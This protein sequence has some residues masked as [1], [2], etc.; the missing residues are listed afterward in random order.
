MNRNIALA[1]LFAIAVSG[2]AFADDITIDTTPFVSSRTRAEVQSELARFEKSGTSPW[3]IRF[4]PLASFKS[5]V[6]SQQVTAAYLA[7]RS[8]VAAFNGE[9]SGSFHL[10]A[11]RAPEAGAT[12]AGRPLNTAR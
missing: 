1:A 2:N 7:S 12:L 8:E 3:S 11:T 9:D 10:A 5:T 6:S 4:N